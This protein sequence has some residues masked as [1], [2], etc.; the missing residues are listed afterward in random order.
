MQPRGKITG[1]LLIVTAMI[2]S[3]TPALADVGVE[4]IATGLSQPLYVTAPAGDDRLFIVEKTGAIKIWKNGAVLATPFLDLSSLVSGGGEQGLLGLAFHPDYATNGRFY[5]NYTDTAGDTRIVEY[6]VSGNPDV[7]DPSSARLLLTVDQPY[8][9]HNGGMID[10]GPDGYLYIPLGDGGAGGDPL[11]NAENPATLLGSILRIDPLGGTPYGI[12]ADNPFVGSA[13][14]DEVWAYGVRNPWRTSFDPVTGDLY[15]ADVGQNAREEVTVLAPSDAGA[16]LGWD[17]L[18]GTRCYEPS[19]GCSSAGTKLPVLE[20]NTS[21]GCAITG[22][23]VY[24]GTEVPDL[25]GRY[26]Y[27]DFCGGW[28]RSF[29]YIGGAATDLRDWTGE[30]GTFPWL[31]SFGT[32]GSGELYFTTLTGSVYKLVSGVTRLAGADRYATSVEISRWA[33]PSGAPVAYVA[34][35]DAFP[36]ALAGSAAA[37]RRGGPL[38]LVAKGVVPGTVQAELSRLSPSEIVVLG[39]TGVVSDAVVAQLSA[40]APTRRVWGA[41]RYATAAAVATD[42]FTAPV[43]VA[44]VATGLDFPDALA[45]GA[46]AGAAGAPLLLTA[47][48]TVPAAT[49]A[50]LQTLSPSEI[51][52]LGGTGVVSDA[53]V[54]QLSA[55][56]PTRRVWGADRY[57]TAAAV[58]ADRFTAATTVFAATGLDFPDALAGAAAAGA[59]GSPVLLVGRDT[60]PSPTSTEITRLGPSEIIVL[61]GSAVVSPQVSATLD[62]LIP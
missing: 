48:D 27:G 59:K 37:A 54:A 14:A 43:S 33:Y 5:V 32:D 39:G 16:N 6:R 49:A 44:Y 52:V 15:V 3:A 11:E 60:V 26:L 25:A 8:G 47:G 10:F 50:A 7:A 12:P 55:I 42:A 17:T 40:I 41:D 46:A 57:A 51:V 2:L 34:A 4:E 38:L 29:T 9:N 58:S 22:G 19:S 24:R 45:G 36:D 23:Y 20:Y 13:G 62:G 31:S 61:G 35:G 53:V 21:E 30:L 1:T 28:I 18:E 56:A